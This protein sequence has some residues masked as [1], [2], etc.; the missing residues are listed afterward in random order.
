LH[1]TDKEIAMF[2]L[3]NISRTAQQLVCVALAA[4]IVTAIL[5]IGAYGAYLATHPGYSVTITQL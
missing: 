2:S 4:L 5:T 3:T 1:G